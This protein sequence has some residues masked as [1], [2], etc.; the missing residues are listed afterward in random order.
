MEYFLKHSTWPDYSITCE[1]TG[2]AV[3][4]AKCGYILV[5]L[6]TR[7]DLTYRPYSDEEHVSNAIISM[8]K[9]LSEI[10]KEFAPNYSQRHEYSLGAEF[11]I[12]KPRVTI[13]AIESGWPFKPGFVPAICCSYVDIRLVPGLTPIRAAQELGT[14]LSDLE[15]SD[16]LAVEQE[17]YAVKAPSLETSA[18]SE[19]V[20]ASTRAF[21]FVTNTKHVPASPGRNSFGDDSLVT[22]KYGIPSVTWGPGGQLPEYAGAAAAAG[23]E[24]EFIRMSD[25]VTACKMYIVAAM[26]IC[27]HER[28]PS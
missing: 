23:G 22:R 27:S 16:E 24:G 6:T 25:V 21:E 11:G 5:K 2:M 8:A 18:D 9:V 12:L 28:A 4:R 26:D 3:T 15:E 13:G 17:I 1:P 19:V 20:R 7:G 14:F 10:E